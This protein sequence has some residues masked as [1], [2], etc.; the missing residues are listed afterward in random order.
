MGMPSP[1]GSVVCPA[2]FSNEPGL[3]R[4]LAAMMAPTSVSA[5]PEFPALIEQLARAIVGGTSR[6]NPKTRHE[7]FGRMMGDVESAYGNARELTQ[8]LRSDQALGPFLL[9]SLMP[10]KLKI[11]SGKGVRMLSDEGPKRGRMNQ[12]YL[13][14]SMRMWVT[15]FRG[16]VNA[17][18]R[19]A[20]R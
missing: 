6:P 11:N 13:V 10:K 2:W 14:I 18:W 1:L 8:I 19:E 20:G 12:N 5:C 7:L 15:E 16:A 17:M 3:S 9:Q 4:C